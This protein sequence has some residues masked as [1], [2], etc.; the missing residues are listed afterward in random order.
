MSGMVGALWGWTWSRYKKLHDDIMKR[1]RPKRLLVYKPGG[2]LC[3]IL[4]GTLAAFLFALMTDRALVRL[5]RSLCSARL[6]PRRRNSPS[7][8]VAIPSRCCL[9]I[10]S[11]TRRLT[12]ALACT[13]VLENNRQWYDGTARY[14]PQSR[15]RKAVQCRAGTR[16]KC[17]TWA[18]GGSGSVQCSAQ[19]REFSSTCCLAHYDP[20][21]EGCHGCS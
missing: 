1:R 12:A 18:C 5:C 17:V 16:V 8:V 21:R 11:L 19:Q 7:S 15:F 14:L 9:R 6:D 20:S 13:Q 3:N 10:S 4:R 2:Q